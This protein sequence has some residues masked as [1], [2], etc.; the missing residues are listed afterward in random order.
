[1]L[2]FIYLTVEEAGMCGGGG[3]DKVAGSRAHA[4]LSET[5]NERRLCGRLAFE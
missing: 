4:F 3:G 2:V 1:M 5:R